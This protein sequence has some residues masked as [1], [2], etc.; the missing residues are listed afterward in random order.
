M[1][2]GNSPY[3]VAGGA[4]GR[5]GDGL[6]R[7]QNPRRAEPFPPRADQ[8]FGVDPLSDYIITERAMSASG[9][10]AVVVCGL[11]LTFSAPGRID[12]MRWAKLRELWDILAH[13]LAR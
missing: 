13:W 8:R 1:R 2:S 3:L 12:P 5:R 4:G 9:V 10:I 11:V 7:P 6:D